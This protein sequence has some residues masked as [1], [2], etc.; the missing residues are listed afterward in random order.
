[1]QVST[2]FWYLLGSRRA[3]LQI[4]AD[5]RAV[6]I[7][8]LFVLSAGLARDYDGEDLIHEPWHLLAPFGA[9]LTTS[10][11]LYALVFGMARAKKAPLPS[12]GSGYRVFLGLFWMTAPLAWLYAIPYERF[13]PPASAT[14]A[15][16]WTLGIVALWRVLLMARVVSVLMD[17]YFWSALLIV[18][19]LADSELLVVMRFL[20]FPLIEVMGGIRYSEPEIFVR[21]VTQQLFGWSCCSLPVWL[22]AG[23]VGVVAQKGLA[24]RGP[25]LAGADPAQSRLGIYTLAWISI[26]IWFFIMP[27]T[28]PEQLLRWSVERDFKKGRIAE[29]LAKMSSHAPT[30]FPPHWIPPP[31]WGAGDVR[32]YPDPLFAFLEA[33][34]QD[35]PATWVQA[36]Y[37]EKFKYWLLTPYLEI[38]VE[39]GTLIRKLLSRF[40]EGGTAVVREAAAQ[41]T[42]GDTILNKYLNGAED[43]SEPGRPEARESPDGR[44]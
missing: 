42:G 11:L 21:G 6:G 33:M 17:Y 40:P 10:F 32:S 14:A 26:A 24:W 22:L 16:L 1:M 37:L 18:L 23:A 39:E 3:I 44:K 20:P 12:F 7:G 4:A 27:F 5:R 8:F 15:N 35:P 29:A 36:I 31:K 25:L 9:S 30:D 28:Q 41:R 34:I 43:K 38:S 13:L 2:L 19:A